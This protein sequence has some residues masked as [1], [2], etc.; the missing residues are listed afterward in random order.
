MAGTAR[1]AQQSLPCGS[2]ELLSATSN[3]GLAGAQL[4]MY[5]KSR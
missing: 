3:H 2:A 5:E 4:V 1:A